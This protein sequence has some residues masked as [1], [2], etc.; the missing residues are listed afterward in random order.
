M[1]IIMNDGYTIESLDELHYLNFDEENKELIIWIQ[2]LNGIECS[3]AH[4][5]YKG[6][7]FTSSSVDTL[8]DLLKNKTQ[9]CQESKENF[10][11]CI[12]N[13]MEYNMNKDRRIMANIDVKNVVRI[14]KS[15]VYISSNDMYDVNDDDKIYLFRP[16]HKNS[17]S[18]PCLWEITKLPVYV[19]YR[20]VYYSLACLT[21]KI[22]L[23]LEDEK[24]KDYSNENWLEELACLRGT[25]IYHMLKMCL[26]KDPS[27]RLIV[28]L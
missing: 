6:L 3:I 13:Q 10:F 25:K 28:N 15:W 12:S 17:L 14:N 21:I 11:H 1:R 5:Q 18:C 2:K 9:I 24:T 8:Y 26:R 22:L 7:K 20:S 4:N 19:D 27:D 16:F 23:N